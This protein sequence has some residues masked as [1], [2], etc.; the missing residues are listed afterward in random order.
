[1]MKVVFVVVATKEQFEY[2]VAQTP[3]ALGL[4]YD[5]TKGLAT[6]M[7]KS[8]EYRMAIDPLGGL[9]TVPY[10]VISAWSK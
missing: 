8:I 4:V 9:R 3:R 6:S 7:D 1:M 2:W 5:A 10:E